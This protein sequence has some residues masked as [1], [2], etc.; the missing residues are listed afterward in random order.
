LE[1]LVSLAFD[2][3]F[4]LFVTCP[5]FLLMVGA[6]WANRSRE[7]GRIVSPLEL[8]TMVGFVVGLWVFFSG[9]N[10]TRLQFNTGIRYMAP[11]FAFAFVPAVLPLLRMP[12]V[13]AAVIGILSVAQAWA[14]AMHRDVERGLGM[15]EPI[16]NVF[17]GGLRLPA[18]ARLS[19]MEAYGRFF[20]FG[21][22]PIPLMLLAAALIYAIWAVRPGPRQG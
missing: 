17:L 22:S 12:R 18:L 6:F 7:R 1:L 13:V 4:G 19:Q 15:A 10:Y 16:L 8:A 2:P 3:R 5:L 20:E 14:L 11:I 21:V 9:S